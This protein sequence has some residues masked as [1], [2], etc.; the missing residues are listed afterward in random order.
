MHTNTG[1]L[2]A[3]AARRRRAEVIIARFAPSRVPQ[4][5]RG[6][7]AFDGNVM[8]LEKRSPQRKP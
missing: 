7:D 4:S 8:P 1:G 3:Q 6:V 5:R 2:G